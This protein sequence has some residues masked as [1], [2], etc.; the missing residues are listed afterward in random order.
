MDEKYNK[1]HAASIDYVNTAVVDA[2]EKMKVWM[3]TNI[4]NLDYVRRVVDKL[5]EAYRG[6]DFTTAYAGAELINQ[7]VI[8]ITQALRDSGAVIGDSDLSNYATL[9]RQIAATGYEICILGKSGKHWSNNEWTDY[10]AQ[11][12]TIPE[13]AVV[14][15]ITPFQSCVIG[16]VD[17]STG[18]LTKQ[19]G[20]TT[21]NVPGLYAQQNGSFVDVLQ[22]SLNFHSLENTRIMLLWYDPEV[23]PHIDYDPNDPDKNYGEYNCIRFST[24]Q[25]M[26][27]SGIHL[28]YDQ[29]VYIVTTDTDGVTNI[30]YYWDGHAYV[31]RFAVPRVA[32]NVTGSPAAKYAWEYKAW[33]NDSR[34]WTIPT[35]NHLLMMYV[36]QTQ[37]NTCLGILNRAYLPQGSS[38]T[39]RQNSSNSAWYV[40]VPSGSVNTNSKTNTYDVIP[41][42]AL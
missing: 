10:I 32:N 30:C 41:V 13:E 36:Y 1:N 18:Y 6:G 7:A 17:S 27:D 16:V 14:G 25:E 22:N 3:M 8:D 38:W 34:Q 29:Q 33:E 42:A 15:M 12:G 28:M 21:D 23:L 19:W 11:Y 39:C 2:W 24:N 35:T 26:Q 4:D 31:K 37:I 20:N 5:H 9:I 40:T